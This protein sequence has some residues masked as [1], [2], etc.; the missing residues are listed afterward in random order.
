MTA[1]LDYL[2]PYTD[3]TASGSTRKLEERRHGGWLL[4]LERALLANQATTSVSGHQHQVAEMRR[5]ADDS[6]DGARPS[7]SFY[8]KPAIT[9]PT[10]SPDGRQPAEGTARSNP[11]AAEGNA[12][13][14][15]KPRK[16]QGVVGDSAQQDVSA[17]I[18]FN[19]YGVSARLSMQPLAVNA[20]NEVLKMVSHQETSLTSMPLQRQVLEAPHVALWEGARTELESEAEADTDAGAAAPDAELLPQS[21]DYARRKLHLFH[22]EDGVH[23]WIRDSEVGEAGV[24][25]IAIALNAE[26]A[27]AGLKLSALTLNGKRVA[28]LL[29]DD[30]LDE[31]QRALHRGVSNLADAEELPEQAS[32]HITRQ[33]A[34]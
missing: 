32:Q 15:A 21:D 18:K 29:M 9:R 26:L 5:G 14:P 4:E 24:Q 11:V 12:T 8:D 25:A 23:A 27:A 19:P 20:T 22:G 10:S 17:P 31:E 6:V 16:A 30:P 1:G 13:T 2:K 3:T 7:M 28:N 34:Y 33:G